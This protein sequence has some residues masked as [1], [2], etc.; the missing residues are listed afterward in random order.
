V[1]ADDWTADL[2]L[3]LADEYDAAALS[4]A[5]KQAQDKAHQPTPE[6]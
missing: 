6:K 1:V 4:A 3:R 5:A 2:L